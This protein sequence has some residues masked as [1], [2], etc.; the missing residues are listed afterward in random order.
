M[1]A[2]LEAAPGCPG[3]FDAGIATEQ[4]IASVAATTATAIWWSAANAPVFLILNGPLPSRPALHQKV[5]L[6]RA[7][8]EDQLVRCGCHV[9]LRG[10]SQLRHLLEQVLL[11]GF[12]DAP[13][14]ARH[15][16]K[17][18]EAHPGLEVHLQQLPQ[19]RSASGTASANSPSP[20]GCAIPPDDRPHRHRPLPSVEPQPLRAISPV[21]VPTPSPT[22][23]HAPQET[24]RGRTNSSDSTDLEPCCRSLQVR[25]RYLQP[26]R[27]TKSM[28]NRSDGHLFNLLDSTSSYQHPPP[29]SAT[30]RDRKLHHRANPPGSLP[31]HCRDSEQGTAAPA[32]RSA[33][34]APVG[35]S[36]VDN[37]AGPSAPGLGA[38]DEHEVRIAEEGE[39][40][41]NNI[42]WHYIATTLNLN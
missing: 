33:R 42:V 39:C 28:A 16:V 9:L 22:T 30:V 27:S 15:T 25:T 37:L 12:A 2:A 35:R 4:N 40:K 32:P 10:P 6:H 17:T 34:N 23:S 1:L 21:R 13:S 11:D 3:V 24:V 36:L 38:P 14:K 19:S 7:F 18:H 29:L 41:K 20:R 31:G 26:H 5:H 8:D